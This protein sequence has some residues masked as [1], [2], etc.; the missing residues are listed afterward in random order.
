M[1]LKEAKDYTILVLTLL[2][3]YSMLVLIFNYTYNNSTL[4]RDD[5][6]QQEYGSKR[7]GLIIKTDYK[8]GCQFYE[9]KNGTLTPRL[10]GN[11]NHLGCK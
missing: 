6:D 1:N 3:Y 4:G 8:T 11:F 9:S 7:S 2:C 10:D 5:S